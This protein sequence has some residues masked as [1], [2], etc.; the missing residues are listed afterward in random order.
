M[1]DE[2]RHERRLPSMPSIE[3]KGERRGVAGYV[4]VSHGK[5]S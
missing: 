4:H 5:L 3:L 2:G 1:V